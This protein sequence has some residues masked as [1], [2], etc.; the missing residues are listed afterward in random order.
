MGEKEN[1]RKHL[2]RKFD[3]GNLMDE[4]LR[5]PLNQLKFISD[6]ALSSDFEE[7]MM[8]DGTPYSKGVGLHLILD[9]VLRKFVEFE[10]QIEALPDKLTVS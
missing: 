9:N 5:E 8:D 2:I 3:V 7:A 10:E 4:I 6:L 1:T